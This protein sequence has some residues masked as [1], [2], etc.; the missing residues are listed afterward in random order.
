MNY[1]LLLFSLLFLLP[2]A[3]RA[4]RSAGDTLVVQTLTFDSIGRA[5]VFHFP[6]TGTFEKVIMQYTMRCHHALVSNSTN[7]EQGC[8]QWDYNCETYL[9]DSTRT[10]SLQSIAPSAV[11]SNYPANT[12]FPY[13][14]IPT[15][16]VTR[17][18]EK[19]VRYPSGTSFIATTGDTSGNHLRM[20]TGME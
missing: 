11:I 9:W 20:E 3:A 16:S 15:Y 4:Q 2:A 12:N 7:T 5:G 6:D 17:R 13:T 19:L 1:R 18:D 8:G 10:D 14:K